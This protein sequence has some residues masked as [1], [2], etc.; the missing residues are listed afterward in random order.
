MD[1]VVPPLCVVVL[2]P[3]GWLLIEA[4]NNRGLGLPSCLARIAY[5]VVDRDFDAHAAMLE[6]DGSLTG[7]QVARAQAALSEMTGL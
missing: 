4:F 2:W 5:C 7:L 1:D 6:S 3:G